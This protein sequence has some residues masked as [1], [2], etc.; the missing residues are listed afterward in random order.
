MASKY[1]PNF[2]ISRPLKGD[3]TGDPHETALWHCYAAHGGVKDL[4]AQFTQRKTEIE[5]RGASGELGPVG[6]TNS[7]KALAAEFEPRLRS[8]AALVDKAK[9]HHASVRQKLTTQSTGSKSADFD[10]AIERGMRKDRT[11]RRFEGLDKAQRREAIRIAMEKNDA[12]FLEAVIGESPSLVDEPTARMI[13]ISLMRSADKA[14]FAQFEELGGKLGSNGEVVAAHESPLTVAGFVLDDTREWIDEQV[15]GL[16]A[17]SILGRAGIDLAG[18]ALALTPDQAKNPSIYR[19]AREVAL[20][21]GKVLSI[22]GHGDAG[23]ITPV[24]DG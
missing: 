6:V 22:M 12:A 24:V 15:G 20:V 23:A 13:E 1:F 4:R 16:D 2:P 21:D 3:G 17:R 8:L 11:I 14:F 19:A 10:Q 18:P 9:A 5:A 7:L